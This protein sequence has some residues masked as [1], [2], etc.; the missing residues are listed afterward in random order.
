MKIRAVTHFSPLTWPFDLNAIQSAARFL[1]LTKVQFETAGYPVQT[2]RLSTPPFM[3]LLGDPNPQTLFDFA[4]TLEEHTQ[5]SGIAF[6][7]IGPV[8]AATPRSLLSPIRAI[9]NLIRS[10]ETIFCSTLVATSETGVNLAAI[11]ATA[12]AIHEIG[13]TT[14]DG[15]G[16]LRFAMLA[17]VKPGGPFFPGSYY[18]QGTAAFGIATEAA[19]IAVT[20]FKEATTLDQARKNLIELLNEHA[21]Q[22]AEAIGWLVDEHNIHFSGVDLSLAPYPEDAVSIA[23]AMEHL[24]IDKFGGHG[25]LFVTAFLTDAIQQAL[26]PLTG[27]SGVMLPVLEDNILAQRAKE[28]C[29]TVNDLLL[30]SAVCGTGLDTV[31]IPGDTTVEQISS[32][33]LDVA[34]LSTVLNKPLTARLLPIPN[35]QAG[36][37]T[38]FDFE[39]FANAGVLPLK[40]NGAVN[41]FGEGIFVPMS[42]HNS[43]F[44]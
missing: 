34:T 31:P 10:T 14:A 5:K 36:D 44:D 29:Y 41:L 8:M 2:L 19:D 11:E 15:F 38:N 13:Q 12:E 16:N 24:G 32:L 3:D 39:Y 43:R 23:G 35:L 21:I 37:V 28:G 27:Y 26:L 4:T 22:L 18:D 1:E 30:Y 6:T 40:D 20:A 7:S 42:G 17:N 33:L 25:T 9:P